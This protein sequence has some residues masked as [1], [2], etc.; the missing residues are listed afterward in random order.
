MD[1]LPQKHVFDACVFSF[2]LLWISSLA[3]E[4]VTNI[5]NKI[6]GVMLSNCVSPSK[7]VNTCISE[8][9]LSGTQAFYFADKGVEIASEMLFQFR[10]WY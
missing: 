6:T 5:V 7:A 10:L 1:K 3:E 8:V 9:G 4:Y 2:E